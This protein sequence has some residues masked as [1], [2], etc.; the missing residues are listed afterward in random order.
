NSLVVSDH[1]SIANYFRLL[2]PDL[3]PKNLEKVVYLDSDIIVLCSL[4]ELWNVNLNERPLAA[5][6][7]VGFS[8]HS[9]L[10]IPEDRKYFNSGVLVIDVFQWRRKKIHISVLNYIRKNPENILFW[11]QDGLNALLYDEWVELDLRW[12]VQHNI[13]LDD[14]HKD[15][16]SETLENP[17]IIHFTG[18]GLKPWQHNSKHPF[19]QKYIEYRKKT[20]WKRFRP[21]GGPLSPRYLFNMILEGF[22]A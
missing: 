6:E 14:E 3:L 18:S 9:R 4:S 1:A 10:S 19:T 8:D 5:V 15:R 11:D 16:F 7:N 22:K 17:F 13:I 21:E 2:I 20:P 12:N